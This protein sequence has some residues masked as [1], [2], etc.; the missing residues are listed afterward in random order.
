MCRKI[1]SILM[2]ELQVDKNTAKIATLNLE[3]RINAVVD[4]IQEGEKK[5][6][7]YVKKLI[8]EIKVGSV[9]QSSKDPVAQLSRIVQMTI[10]DFT[11]NFKKLV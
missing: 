2:S 5:Y 11:K 8:D 1:Y 10:P 6:L 4:A 9:D 3:Y 7:A